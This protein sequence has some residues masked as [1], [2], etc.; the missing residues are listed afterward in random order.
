M[1]KTPDLSGL[2][3]RDLERRLL[4]LDMALQRIVQ[5]QNGRI[6]KGTPLECDCVGCLEKK[7]IARTA[8]ERGGTAV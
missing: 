8:L 3:R 1:L 2:S 4:A 6:A 7:R 5:N